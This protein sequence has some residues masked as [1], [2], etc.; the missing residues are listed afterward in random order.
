MIK[1][2]AA[3][4]WG[5]IAAGALFFSRISSVAA[6][7]SHSDVV[8]PFQNDAGMSGGGGGLWTFT[9]LLTILVTIVQWI[10]TIF[11]II[12]VLF[13]LLAAYNFILGGSDEK[14]IATAKNQLKYGV[15]AIVVALLSVG[16]A[17][18]IDTFLR[19]GA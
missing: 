3:F 2:T 4:L 9:S 18:A 14:K 5:L 1:K 13:F 12:A 17:Y 19:T 7:A 11:F 16:A 8:A 15:I 6:Q 10:Y